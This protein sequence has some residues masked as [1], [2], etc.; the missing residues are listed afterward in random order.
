MRTLWACV[1]ICSM[2]FVASVARAEQTSAEKF[3]FPFIGKVKAT[4]L[5]IRGGPSDKYG[6][7]ARLKYGDTLTVLSQQNDWYQVTPTAGIAFYV[8]TKYLHVTKDNRAEVSAELLNVRT[9]TNTKQPPLS[10]LKRGDSVTVVA[11]SGEWTQINAPQ[12]IGV[13]VSSKYIDYVGP[14]AANGNAAPALESAS[15]TPENNDNNATVPSTP[16]P[17]ADSAREAQARELFALTNEKYDAECRKNPEQWD[18][19]GVIQDYQSVLPLTEDESMRDLINSRLTMV[20][21]RMK[22]RDQILHAVAVDHEQEAKLKEIEAKYNALMAERQRMESA[23]K[24]SSFDAVGWLHPAGRFIGRPSPWR[25][26]KGGEILE[27]VDV[28]EDSIITLADYG[29]SY[30]GVMGHRIERNGKSLL[31]VDKLTILKR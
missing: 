15:P 14:A 23:T 22:M 2:G 24:E 12:G 25:L 21:L 17:A 19:T 4:E 18:F 29:Y 3:Q 6:V 11:T 27:Y 10:Q 8:S 16:K 5:N 13:W 26:E 1:V 7:L 9:A 28:P 31:V 20:D 30:V